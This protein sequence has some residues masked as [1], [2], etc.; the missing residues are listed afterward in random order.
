MQTPIQYPDIIK[1]IDM[2]CLLLLPWLVSMCQFNWIT[3]N[4]HNILHTD[5]STSWN[6]KNQEAVLNVPLKVKLWAGADLMRMQ[7]VCSVH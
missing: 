5:Q 2:R 4:W 6:I 3:H 7:L 1:I